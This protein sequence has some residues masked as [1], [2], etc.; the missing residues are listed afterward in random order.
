MVISLWYIPIP[1]ILRTV[2]IMRPF[3]PNTIS[4]MPDIQVIMGERHGIIPATE[5]RIMIIISSLI[6]GSI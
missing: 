1:L 3:L 2:M 4:G 6:S 5:N